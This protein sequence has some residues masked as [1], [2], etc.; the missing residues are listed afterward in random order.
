M[1]DDPGAKY[2]PAEQLHCV[3]P[4]TEL[5]PAKNQSN[6]LL[7]NKSVYIRDSI[8]DAADLMDIQHKQNR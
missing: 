8:R 6:K 3:D 4:A 1:V 5:D 7:I 2:D